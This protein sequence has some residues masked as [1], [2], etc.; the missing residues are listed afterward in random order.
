MN[1]SCPACGQFTAPGK[2]CERCG[3]PIQHVQTGDAPKT[4]NVE[5]GGASPQRR[6]EQSPYLPPVREITPLSAAGTDIPPILEIDS[7]CLLFENLPGI[8]RFRF[9]PR[10]TAEN[11]SIALENSITGTTAKSHGIVYLQGIREIN[12]P[13]PAQPAGLFLWHLALSYEAAGRKHRFEGDVQVLVA[14]PQEAQKVAG[15]LS[16]TITNNIHNGNASDIHISQR[17]ADELAR[18]GRAENPFDELRR[19]VLGANRAWVPVAI[20]LAG[21]MPVLP[22]QPG[23]AV[24]ETLTLDIGTAKLHFFS[25]RTIRLGRKRET[26][27]ISLRPPD[28]VSDMAYRAVSRAQCH[29]G[30]AGDRVVVYDGQ[31]DDSRVVRPSSYGTYWN[32]RRIGSSVELSA[33][34]TGVLSLSGAASSGSVALDAKACRPMRACAT[35]PH[36][37]RTWCGDGRRPALMLTRRDGV[38]ERFVALWS[39]FPMEE[40]DPSFEGV[41]IFRKDG[42]FAWRRGRRCG[43]LVPGET[44]D[45]DFGQVKVS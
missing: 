3:K 8:L 17:A 36:A 40:A 14:R 21:G 2:F 44:L 42:G 6:T 15:Q 39:C 23:A 31:M 45:T 11:V 1:I 30:H 26:N 27:E 29:F 22:V 10:A 43:W 5:K 41:V 7:L 18:L 38:S 9:D 4:E 24:R 25:G 13:I 35:C 12:V 28:G 33:G 37:N 19:I 32:D 16:V 34:E 20:D